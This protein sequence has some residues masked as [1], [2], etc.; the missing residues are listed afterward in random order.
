MNDKT[1]PSL[2]HKLHKKYKTTCIF[3]S[4]ISAIT[5][6][7]MMLSTTIDATS[8]FVLNRP[9]SGIFEL[10]E[11]ILVVCVFM[12]IAW[13]QIERGHIRIEVLLMR[14]SPRT[15]H[16]LN[17]LSRMVALIF[18]GILFYQTF[19]GFQDS[20]RIREF[21]WGSVQMPIWWAKGL[22]PLGCLLL[23]I[24]L[25]FDIWAEVRSFVGNEEIEIPGPVARAR[26]L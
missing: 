16:V 26:E 24:Q 6:A 2:F 21:R 4:S 15:R 25:I 8:R 1:K 5:I 22:V 9:I 3:L 12:G 20:F 13:T 7:V 23:M 11:V 17:V 18:V 19:Q 10:N 14:V